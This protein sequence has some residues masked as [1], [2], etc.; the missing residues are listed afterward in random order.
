MDD[1]KSKNNLLANAIDMRELVRRTGLTSRALRFYE[2]RGLIAPLRTYNGKRLFGPAELERVHQIVVLKSAG[3]SLA[4]MKDLFDGK[5]L[6][7]TALLHAQLNMLDEESRQIAN[8]QTIINFALSRIARS[9]PLNAETFCALIETGDKMLKQEPK[10][11]KEVTDRYFS[12][13]EKAHWAAQWAQAPDDFDA[14]F[15]AAQWKELGDAI[16]AALP[17]KPDSDAAQFFVDKWYDLLKPMAEFYTPEMWNGAARLYDNMDQW[18][19]KDGGKS[20]GQPDP[21]FNKEVW[22]FIK[23]ATASRIAKNGASSPLPSD[24]LAQQNKKD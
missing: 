12:P 15:Y 19:G 10:E 13:Q 4:Q 6:D 8:A 2:T 3:L 11:W 18:T 24:F 1:S 20:T 14:E 21:G 16:K 17:M 23:L 5:T 7:L 22:D 9:E